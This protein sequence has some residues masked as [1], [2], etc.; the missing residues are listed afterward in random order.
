MTAAGRG[1]RGEALFAERVGRHSHIPVHFKF[2]ARQGNFAL[3]QSV[4]PRRRNMKLLASL[5]NIYI[6]CP[7]NDNGARLD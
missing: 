5:S 2:C 3:P 1:S 4:G 6:K 7:Y